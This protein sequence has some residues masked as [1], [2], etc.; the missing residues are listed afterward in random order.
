MRLRSRV[1]DRLRKFEKTLYNK[2][3]PYNDRLYAFYL[4]MLPVLEWVKPSFYGIGLSNEETETEVF[5]MVNNIFNGYNSDKSSLVPYVENS[6]KWQLDKCI[7]RLLKTRV[8]E[9]SGFLLED[10]SYFLE[11]NYYWNGNKVLFEDRYIG[12]CFTRSE[13]YLIHKIIN[14]SSDRLS[15]R[16]MSEDFK[17][18]RENL[19]LRLNDLKEV[20]TTGGYNE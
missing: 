12:K 8:E 19:R 14:T 9:P 20:L 7:R 4:L 16:L 13:K 15:H 11:E 6:I 18:S 17:I 10:D 1:R 2:D 5:L 3:H